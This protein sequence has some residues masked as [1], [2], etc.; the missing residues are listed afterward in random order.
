M[1]QLFCI[2]AL[3]YSPLTMMPIEVGGVMWLDAIIF[4]K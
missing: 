2:F 4:L 1:C 3:V